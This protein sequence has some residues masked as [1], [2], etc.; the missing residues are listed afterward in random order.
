[1]QPTRETDRVHTLDEQLTK[2]LTDVHSIE[3]QA[4]AQLRTAP[5]LAGDPQIADS[6]SR[7][8]AETEGHETLV[9]QRLEARNSRPAAIKD[10]VGTL[11]GKGFVLFARSQPDTPGKLVA[12][13]YSY[14]HMELAAYD[15][16]SRVADRAGDRES[17]EAARHILQQERAMS[18]RL[19]ESFDRAV[20]ASLRELDP[21]DLQDQLDKYLADAHAIESQAAQLLGKGPELA[22]ASELASA[23]E[24]HLSETYEHLRLI[25]DRLRARGSSSSKVKDAALRLGALSWGLFFQAQPDTPAKLAAFAYAFE[26]LEVAA[27]ELLARVAKRAGDTETEAVAQRILAD[28]RAAAER[29]HSLFEQALDVSLKE[30]GVSAR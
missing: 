27:Y 1:V 23:Y 12:H 9:R 3:Q 2:Y 14:E 8:L 21:D 10:L 25:D 6:F 15:L 22:G 5:Q 7:H 11:T 24:D 4:L 30:Q 13:A 29:I 28:E 17:A 18:E 20:E 19:A 16:L 26:H